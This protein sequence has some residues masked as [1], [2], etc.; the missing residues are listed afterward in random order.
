MS[1]F[2]NFENSYAKELNE[3]CEKFKPAGFPRSE[4]LLKNYGL[5]EELGLDRKFIDSKECLNIFSGTSLPKSSNPIAQA[6]SGHQFGHFNPQLGDGRAILLGEIKNKDI[7]LKGIG[8]TP[9]SRRGDGK[10]ALGPVL[11]EYVISEFMHSINIPTTRSLSAI[12]TNEIVLRETEQPGGI[13]TRVAKSHIRIG[14]FEYA[15]CKNN[16]ILKTLADYSINRHYPELK[17]T[18]NKYL[19]FFA[20]VCDKQAY[21]VSKWMSVGFVHGVMNTDNMAISGETIDYGPCA[22]MDR[23]NPRTVFSSIDHNGR[24]SYQNQPA[25]LVWNLSKFAETLIPLINENREKSV[26]QLTEVLQLT[27][28]S[29]Q[30]YFYRDIGK[31]LG[32][33][34]INNRN[35]ELINSYLKILE[36]ESIDFTLSFTDLSKVLIKEKNFN[37]SVFS[38]V[39]NFEDWYQNWIRE[40]TIKNTEIKKLA[41]DMNSINPCYIPRNHIIEKAL[42]NATNNDMSEINNLL[43]I[44]KNPFEKQD[45][46]EDYLTPS[47]SE[48]PYVTFCGT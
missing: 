23:Y 3:I 10:S 2:I 16:E 7:Q 13:L 12:K 4:I 21:L 11:R 6:Y 35:I 24:Y 8:Q 30:E 18:D 22:L 37:D 15:R 46:S 14:T 34:N 36:S 33:L 40:L 25:I 27:M 1:H 26:K 42:N 29:Y 9:F 19:S 20:A 32:L 39:K 28:P 47:N 48:S 44:F 41:K 5:A 45:I 31:K 43:E 38:S 17:N